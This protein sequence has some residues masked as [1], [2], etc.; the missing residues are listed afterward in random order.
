MDFEP[1]ILAVDDVPDN[2]LLL[3]DL[4]EERGYHVSIASNVDVALKNI[5]NTPPDLILLDI[6]MP[7]I[8]GYKMASQLKSDPKTK[9]IP[10]I[11]LS[12]L[13]DTAL[14][15]K[16]FRMGGADYVTKP[17]QV[18]EVVARIENQITIQQQ[19]NNLKELEGKLLEQNQVLEQRNHYL[20]V[21]LTLTK[22]MNTADT[23]DSAIAQVLTQ[24]CQVI[25][26]DYGEAWVLNS[27]GTNLEKSEAYYARY[28]HCN[29]CYNSPAQIALPIKKT[30]VETTTESKE[31]QLIT[32]LE[33]IDCIDI[34]DSVQSLPT[35]VRE[36]GFQH[37]L[38][39]PI[40]FKETVLAVLIF[41]SQGSNLDHQVKRNTVLSTDE[42]NLIE[43]AATQLGTL[44]QRLR[45]EVALKKANDK[46]QHLV[47]Y[48]GLTEIANRRR[49]DEYLD[50]QWRQGKRDR[51]ELS[52]ILCDLDAFKA[53]N[54][55]L[56]HQAGDQCL[57]TVAQTI[58]KIVNRPLDL[59]ARYGGEEIAV[60]LPYTSQIGAF[61][62]GEKICEAIKNL[63][64]PHPH[65]PVSPYVT[66]SAGVSSII[67]RDDC[68]PK[69]LIRMA[70]KAL[71][72]AKEQG[73][74]RV[75][76]NNYSFEQ[77]E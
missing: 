62:L 48:D 72:Q 33:K 37:L 36:A 10:I 55:H 5:Y 51:C 17:F 2:L 73:R 13:E 30:I 54:D 6:C 16:A 59:V 25:N 75:A 9:E 64:I 45:T 42:V 11:F 29:D 15:V 24:L 8:S 22:L 32:D 74:D 1:K 34:S 4:L 7:E 60:L 44:M 69:L 63:Q 58:E 27:V 26:W 28:D 68:A 71:Y 40:I 46:L 20:Q 50:E 18:E 35:A 3:C 56:G 38:S 52:L 21:L 76:L 19:K 39:V 57:Q 70:D 43:S 49:F 61:K 66:L 41:F 23:V 31:I 67:P 53:Y 14:K 12:V 65:S 47:S 77:N